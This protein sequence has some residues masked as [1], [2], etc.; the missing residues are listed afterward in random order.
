VTRLSPGRAVRAASFMPCPA[1]HTLSNVR[2]LRRKTAD[3]AATTAQDE[4]AD[5]HAPGRTPAKGK[6]TPKRRDAQGRRR[7]PVPPPPKNQREAARRARGTRAERR[8]AADERRRRMM[9]GDDRVLMPRDRGPVRAYVRDIVDS[10]RHLMGIFMPLVVFVFAA[11]LLQNIVIQQ[12]STLIMLA[13]LLT[14]VIEGTILGRTV[15]KKVRA[16]FP[17][18]Q[19]RAFSLGWYAFTRAMQLRRLRVPRP[20]V[21]PKDAATVG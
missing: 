21:S 7:G 14:M 2:F 20:R 4:A 1:S 19:D 5:D 8:Q 16:K 13:V 12:Y 9:E 10:R 15:N 11:T 17:D 3:E 18:T 6:P